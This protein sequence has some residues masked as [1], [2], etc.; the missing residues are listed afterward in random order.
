[1]VLRIRDD[2]TQEAEVTVDPKYGPMI[3]IPMGSSR[4]F[5][6]GPAKARAILAHIDELQ[7]FVDMV[8]SG[9]LS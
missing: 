2:S 9:E 3:D 1:M 8:D 7:E 5:R 4:P 6:M